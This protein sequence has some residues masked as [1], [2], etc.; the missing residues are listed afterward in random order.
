MKKSINAL[1]DDETQERWKHATR[2]RLEHLAG[3]W[4]NLN[5]TVSPFAEDWWNA[6]YLPEKSRVDALRE[7]FEASSN[8]WAQSS[9]NADV[10]R[11]LIT[12]ERICED[13]KK[14]L[15]E[16]TAAGRARAAE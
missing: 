9:A 1:A 6:I 16:H 5:Q 7:R 12:L 10:A 2:I 8:E 13:A 3:A 11:E 14:Q 4:N 15:G